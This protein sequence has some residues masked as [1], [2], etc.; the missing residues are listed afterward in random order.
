MCH[1]VLVPQKLCDLCYKMNFQIHP[2]M[3]GIKIS[4]KVMESNLLISCLNFFLRF[5][6][7]DSDERRGNE[8]HFLH[9]VF[10]NGLCIHRGSQIFLQTHICTSPL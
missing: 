8:L 4:F 9:S 3:L 5:P 2:K 1:Y 6:G 10:T 7:W